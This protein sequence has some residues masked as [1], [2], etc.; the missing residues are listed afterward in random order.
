MK[1]ISIE[2]L[3]CCLVIEF[4]FYLIFSYDFFFRLKDRFIYES[5][6]MLCDGGMSRSENLS[7]VFIYSNCGYC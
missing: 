4:F 1:F 7:D 2:V 5:W 3:V 6:C